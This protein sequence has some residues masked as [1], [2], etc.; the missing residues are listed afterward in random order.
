MAVAGQPEAAERVGRDE[1]EVLAV[2][3]LDHE[4]VGVLEEEL[5]DGRPLLLVDGPLHVLDPHL[6]Q[7]L[8]HRPHVLT[9][10][11]KLTA[12]HTYAATT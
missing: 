9:L 1:F 3:D 5:V 6:L 10:Q 7:P 4:A 2:A 8:L 12:R 11:P